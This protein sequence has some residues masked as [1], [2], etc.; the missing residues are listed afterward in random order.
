MQI[1]P[2]AKPCLCQSERLDV[3]L[4]KGR[5]G[6]LLQFEN[7]QQFD[8]VSQAINKRR[9]PT[10]NAAYM[11][12]WRALLLDF[13]CGMASPRYGELSGREPPAVHRKTDTEATGDQNLTRIVPIPTRSAS[14]GFCGGLVGT[15]GDPRS[16]FGLV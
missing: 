2:F 8:L 4:L 16:R 10:T 3:L 13:G 11:P 6:E 1:G 7:A 14:E 15:D 9:S 5:A 12:L